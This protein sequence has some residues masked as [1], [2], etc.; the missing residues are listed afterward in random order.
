[1]SY[2]KLEILTQG[3]TLDMVRALKDYANEAQAGAFTD[4][5]IHALLARYGGS[6]V[7]V[8]TFLQNLGDSRRAQVEKMRPLVLL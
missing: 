1:M 7:Q 4:S 8:L 3:V 5:E 6:M 2:S